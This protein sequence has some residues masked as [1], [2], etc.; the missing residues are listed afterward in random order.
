MRTSVSKTLVA[1]PAYNEEATI[2]DV[3]ARVRRSMPEFDL[4]VV[5][6]GSRDKTEQILRREGVL[7]T[8]HLCNLGYGR[9]IQTAIKYA[10]R[11]GYE[12]LITLDADGQHRPEQ[13]LALY[14]AYCDKVWDCLVGSRYVE[15][16]NYRSAPF[17]RRVGMQLFSLLTK[18]ATGRRFYDTTSG[19]KIMRRTVFVPL[20]EWHFVDFHAEAIVYLT[21]LGFR[22]GEH[23][24][25]IDERR[26]GESMYSLISH[27]VYPLKT[28]T[29]VFLGALQA[30]LTRRKGR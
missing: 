9:A 20:T 17:G 30:D 23:P 16:H 1:I 27:L 14:E 10:L 2:A 18:L 12:T 8:T 25:T 19:L 24:I 21:R 5:N 13:I 22:V 3:V 4:L 15:T 28:S 7:V 6:D 29:M 26:H 11:Q